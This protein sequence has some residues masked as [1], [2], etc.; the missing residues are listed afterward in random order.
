MEMNNFGSLM[1]PKWKEDIAGSELL[2]AILRFNGVHVYDGFPWFVNLAHT[3][4]EL[5]T[6]L[7]AFKKVRSK[8]CKRWDFRLRLF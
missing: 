8:Q 3:Q 4:L 5:D 7:E 6:V 2:F 1:K